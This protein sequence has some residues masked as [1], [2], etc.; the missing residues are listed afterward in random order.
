MAVEE[1]SETDRGENKSICTIKK[2]S[3]IYPS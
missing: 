2:T 1:Q 3:L